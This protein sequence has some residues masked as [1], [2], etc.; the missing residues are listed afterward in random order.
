MLE[1][2]I[3]QIILFF[4]SYKIKDYGPNIF[5]LIWLLRPK[6]INRPLRTEISNLKF[7][8]YITA[9]NGFEP[10]NLVIKYINKNFVMNIKNNRSFGNNLRKCFIN[11][12]ILEPIANTLYEPL[13][14]FAQFCI[15]S[16]YNI[17]IILTNDNIIYY[18]YLLF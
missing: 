13:E 17:N 11:C 10:A 7:L 1:I 12:A 5:Q 15:H 14:N 16:K 8:R 9:G 18:A 2:I 3:P 4:Y 6:I